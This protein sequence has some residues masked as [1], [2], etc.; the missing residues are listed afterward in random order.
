MDEVEAAQHV[1]NTR[2][3]LG[4][5]MLARGAYEDAK[6]AFGSVLQLGDSPTKATLE[7]AE[8]GLAEAEVGEFL[9][10]E[11][12]AGHG[13]LPVTAEEVQAL[14]KTHLGGQQPRRSSALLSPR[15]PSAAVTRVTAQFEV[16]FTQP[17]SIGLVLKSA[18]DRQPVRVADIVAGS[19]A[20]LQPRIRPGLV[21]HAVRGEVVEGESFGRIT[22]MVTAQDRPLVL[23]FRT[24]PP[25]G[26]E[27][28]DDPAA[29]VMGGEETSSGAGA[30]TGGSDASMLQRYRGNEIGIE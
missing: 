29:D 27:S 28:V 4:S 10:P 13:V 8:R 30:G 18:A 15:S 14:L 9:S 11:D 22:Q 3:E 2:V 12:L 21:L 16:V 6:V 5:R 24:P 17:G 26:R 1:A 19:P 23:G 20:A 25:V 7:L